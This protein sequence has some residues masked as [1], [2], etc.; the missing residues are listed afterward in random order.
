M[1]RVLKNNSK[2]LRFENGD[3]EL[4][5]IDRR[6]VVKER[7]PQT[8]RAG[9]RRGQ[10]HV[11]ACALWDGH[12]AAQKQTIVCLLHALEALGAH[13]E[14]GVRNAHADLR[15][16]ARETVPERVVARRQTVGRFHHKGE[17]DTVTGGGS[18]E[19]LSVEILD[20]DARPGSVCEPAAVA[21][22]A[23]TRGALGQGNGTVAARKLDSL[24]L[25]VMDHDHAW[26]GSSLHP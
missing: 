20:S 26:Y 15:H 7:D 11:D 18:V 9:E 13:V 12:R 6:V 16:L 8:R 24:L 17:L 14:R 3:C 19:V 5:R 10:R 21:A 2:S 25:A 4:D 22:H 1:R 23:G